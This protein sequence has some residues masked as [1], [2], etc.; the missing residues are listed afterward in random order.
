MVN[1]GCPGRKKQEEEKENKLQNE[2][3]N[4]WSAYIN[5]RKKKERRAVQFNQTITT[6]IID[7]TEPTLILSS[8]FFTII[9]L[10]ER[11]RRLSS[12][13][14]SFRGPRGRSLLGWLRRTDP[15]RC[16]V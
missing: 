12:G 4:S 9:L 10:Y 7:L 11:E 5:N 3:R 1:I 16:S 8:A 15:N 2:R 14:L 6:P 13:A